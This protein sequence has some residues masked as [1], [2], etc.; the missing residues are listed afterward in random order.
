MRRRFDGRTAPR[1]LVELALRKVSGVAHIPGKRVARYRVPVEES[2]QRVWRDQE[3]FDTSQG[4]HAN[5]PDRFF[6]KLA[7]GYLA[8]AR[9]RGA[10]VGDALSYLFPA[11]ELLA[12]ALP[13]MSAVAAD[14]HAA[15]EVK[16]LFEAGRSRAAS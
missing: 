16:E 10:Y 3:E 11:R 15:D 12:F 4:A 2:G 1:G 5:W 8:M 6:A 9:N 13:L 14:A 7:D